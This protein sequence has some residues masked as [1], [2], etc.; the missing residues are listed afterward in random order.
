MRGL[1]FGQKSGGA[2]RSMVGSKIETTS[3]R[4]K[5]LGCGG[6]GGSDVS[7]GSGECNR[8]LG[9]ELPEEAESVRAHRVK[10]AE[11]KESASLRHFGVFDC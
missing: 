11:E 5:I 1:R 8:A 3:G 7:A 6:C 4:P 2:S 10:A 9:R